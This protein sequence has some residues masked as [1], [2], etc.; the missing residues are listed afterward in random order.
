MNPTYFQLLRKVE[1]LK[2]EIEKSDKLIKSL[3]IS[4]V[5]FIGTTI[6]CLFFLS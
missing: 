1:H 2:I 3:I 5:F 4:N 6:F